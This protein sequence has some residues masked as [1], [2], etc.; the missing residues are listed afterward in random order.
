VCNERVV[1]PK[2]VPSIDYSTV[3][4]TQ[5]KLFRKIAIVGALTSQ[6]NNERE[7]GSC[8]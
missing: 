2:Q 7:I 3:G 5:P 6:T 1:D 4:L 8:C